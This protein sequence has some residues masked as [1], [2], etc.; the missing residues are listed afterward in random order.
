MKAQASPFDRHVFIARCVVLCLAAIREK[1]VLVIPFS[2]Y[3]FQWFDEVEPVP[4]ST[5]GGFDGDA[6]CHC[7]IELVCHLLHPLK[8]L[9]V[10]TLGNTH[11]LCC[12]AG[13]PHFGQDVNIAL[14]G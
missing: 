5:V 2:I 4:I 9:A 10:L 11:R 13:V 14:L 8:R 6:S 12:D 7:R 3:S 1:M